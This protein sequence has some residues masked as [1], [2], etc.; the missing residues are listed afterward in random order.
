MEG[1]SS[2]VRTR[3]GGQTKTVF[4]PSLSPSEPPPTTINSKLGG[5]VKTSLTDNCVPSQAKAAP[6]EGGRSQS[7]PRSMKHVNRNKSA[8]S[9]SLTPHS[10]SVMRQINIFIILNHFHVRNL[11]KSNKI[12]EFFE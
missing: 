7:H 5:G 2:A 10:S 8:A 3:G 9:P 4:C 11:T 1:G 6:R 12:K